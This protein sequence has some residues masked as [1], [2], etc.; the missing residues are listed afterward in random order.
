MPITDPMM[1]KF[2]NNIISPKD[3]HWELTGPIDEKFCNVYD[4][5]EEQEEFPDAPNN[6]PGGPTQADWYDFRKKFVSHI[7]GEPV[8]PESGATNSELIEVML[9]GKP[10]LEPP[11]SREELLARV[12]SELSGNAVKSNTSP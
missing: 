3:T 7:N 8:C 12:L 10:E 4:W 5:Q 11:L 2:F 6:P 9:G 1:Q